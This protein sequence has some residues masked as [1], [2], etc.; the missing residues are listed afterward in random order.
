MKNL[1]VKIPAYVSSW[2][3]KYFHQSAYGMPF[4]FPSE[5]II[6]FFSTFKPGKTVVLYRGINKYNNELSMIVSWTYDRE[7]AKNYIKKG[8]KIIER[9]FSP[10]EILLDTTRLNKN[11]KKLLGYDYAIDDKEGLILMK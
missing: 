10:K 11:Q 7:I 8:G 5:K 4:N 9:F 6:K 2:A 1:D 3:D